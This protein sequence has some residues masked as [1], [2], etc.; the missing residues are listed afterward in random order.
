MYA[1]LDQT[2]MVFLATPL[3]IKKDKAQ[4]LSQKW[5]EFFIDLHRN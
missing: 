4:T 2:V 3:V 5:N 1:F